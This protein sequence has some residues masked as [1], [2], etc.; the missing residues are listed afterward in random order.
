MHRAFLPRGDGVWRRLDEMPFHARMTALND[1][2]TW[3]DGDVVRALLGYSDEHW[4]GHNPWALALLL[5][6]DCCFHGRS[7]R[8]LDC[9]N[10]MLVEV[11]RCLCPIFDY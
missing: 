5:R 2:H 6:R 8:Q 7:R 9:D 1:D 10:Y 11:F 4:V 3:S